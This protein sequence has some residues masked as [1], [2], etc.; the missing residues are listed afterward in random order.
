VTVPAWTGAW[1]SGIGGWPTGRW[2]ARRHIGNG[3]GTLARGTLMT[4][5]PAISAVRIPP[6]QHRTRVA[7][8]RHGRGAVWRRVGRRRD[9]T[10]E[11]PEAVEPRTEA[12]W[13]AIPVRSAAAARGDMAP[14]AAAPHAPV[15]GAAGMLGR[16]GRGHGDALG[17]AEQRW[18][19]PMHHF[20]ATQRP[21]QGRGRL[22]I[23]GEKPHAPV[24]GAAR[25]SSHSGRGPGDALGSAEQ[26]RQNPMHYFVATQRPDQGRGRLA[27]AG[28]K[29]HAPEAACHRAAPPVDARRRAAA[30]PHAPEP[31]PGCGCA[32]N[33]P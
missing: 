7:R 16:P 31:A 21:D 6:L 25:M 14:A 2:T 20:A 11:A 22:A 24:G 27:T 8:P 29:P 10:A 18:Q 33:A 30:E 28:G 26:R 23:A 17:S 1:H 15:G 4:P 32:D 9:R 12:A 13:S 19:D 5:D 3:Y